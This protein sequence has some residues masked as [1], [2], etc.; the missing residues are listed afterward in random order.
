MTP[1]T[2]ETDFYLWTQQQAD[3]LRQG[4][5]SEV[6][7]AHLVDEIEDMGGSERHALGSYLK[8]I[9]MHLLKWQY[10]PQRR[11]NSWRLSIRNGRDGVDRLIEFRT[12]LERKM[13][14]QIPAEYRRARTAAA[15]ETGLPLTTFPD[16]CPFTVEQITSDWWPD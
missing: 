10:Q 9:L 1:V 3:L 14:E 5:L 11:G 8:N 6:D 7:T 15:D 12:S 2:Y 13:T 4:L 16:V